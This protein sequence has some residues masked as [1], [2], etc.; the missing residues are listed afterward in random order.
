VESDDLIPEAAGEEEEAISPVAVEK[1]DWIGLEKGLGFLSSLCL[2]V[3]D[4]YQSLFALIVDQIQY[5]SGSDNKVCQEAQLID[6]TTSPVASN[7][8]RTG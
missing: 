5:V 7:M 4:C 3:V 8:G 1:V 6:M 2:A